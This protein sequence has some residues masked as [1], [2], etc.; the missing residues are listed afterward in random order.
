MRQVLLSQLEKGMVIP[1]KYSSD[2]SGTVI[3]GEL[4][5]DSVTFTKSGRVN[6]RVIQTN[7]HPCSYTNGPI[8]DKLVTIKS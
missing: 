6:V 5:I 2:G 7:G 1:E 4:I 3:C 8:K